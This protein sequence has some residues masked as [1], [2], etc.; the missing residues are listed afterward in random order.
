[1]HVGSK[2]DFSI[3]PNAVTADDPRAHPQIRGILDLWRVDIR[4]LGTSR[5]WSHFFFPE[6]QNY[7][8]GDSIAK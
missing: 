6:I 8:V 4:G 5:E 7:R 2:Y 1:M 3:L